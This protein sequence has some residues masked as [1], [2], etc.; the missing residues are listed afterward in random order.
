LKLL[1]SIVGAIIVVLF[2][3]DA[4][5]QW[6]AAWRFIGSRS[7]RQRTRERWRSTTRLNVLGE[8]IFASASFLALNVLIAAVL[9]FAFVG[10]LPPVHEWR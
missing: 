9:F 10:P 4:F 3:V 5:L 8:V 6:F 1:A 7:F 2:T